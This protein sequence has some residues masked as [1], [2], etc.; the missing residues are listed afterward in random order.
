MVEHTISTP[1]T[2][3]SK[4]GQ[5]GVRRFQ[6]H[7]TRGLLL[8]FGGLVALAV[9]A[10]LAL[11]MWSAWKNTTGLLRD[12]SEATISVV[13][14]RIDSYLQPAEDQLQH[15]ASQIKSG[16]LNINDDAE[17][18]AYLSGSLAA[19][20]QV[21]S[22][23]F[24]NT[25]WRMG[26][27]LRTEAGVVFRFVD[28]SKLKV[29]RD[30]AAAAYK[31][32]GPYWGEIIFPE[33][34]KQALISLRSAVIRDGKPIGVLAANV[35]VAEL[36]TMLDE[37]ARELGG[38]GFILYSDRSVVAHAKLVTEKYDIG[39]KKPLPTADQIGDPILLGFLSGDGARNRERIE[40]NTGVRLVNVGDRQFGVLSRQIDRYGDQPWLVGVAFPA[41]DVL[42]ELLRLRWAAIAG[43]IVLL[44]SLVFAYLF[45]RYL[46]VPVNQLAN[47]AHDISELSLERVPRLGS[48]LFTEL[49]DASH[50]FNSMVVGLKWFETYVP[51]NLVHKLVQQGEESVSKSMVRE[52][53]VMFTDIVGFTTLS[54]AMSAEETAGFLNDH[55]ARLS[56][57][58]ET[59]SGTIDKFIGDAI[60][61]FW[62]V[63]DAQPDHALRACRAALAIRE[64]TAAENK[65]RRER[66]LAPVRVRIGIHTGEVIVGNIGAPGRINYPIVGDTVNTANRLEQLGKQLDPDAVDVA[67]A[68]SDVTHAKSPGIEARAAGNQTIRGREGEMAVYLL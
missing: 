2:L 41:S 6:M 30:A 10:V 50:A 65:A 1:A 21:R 17:L 40:R 38:Q 26:F 18:A 33:T 12:K 4:S 47:A 9:L 45:A 22:V 35:R 44:V 43:G 54:E 14:S 68:I 61:A 16:D 3:E 59:E 67:I 39:P 34:A 19:T 32:D 29:I 37:T 27:A 53:T 42:D 24:I 36:S 20:P 13:L 58:I 62:G 7:I 49:T 23:V 52:A 48:S 64:V 57:C 31:R 66:G 11:G 8:G 28:V 60:M 5:V 56:Q 63:P 25:D 46:S 15:L 51:K 55:F